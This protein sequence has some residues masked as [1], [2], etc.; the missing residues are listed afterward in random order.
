MHIR[1]QLAARLNL[2]EARVQVQPPPPSAPTSRPL[3]PWVRHY[4]P[5]TLRDTPS[6]TLHWLCPMSVVTCA[7]HVPGREVTRVIR[8]FLSLGSGNGT[9]DGPRHLLPHP[10]FP[11]DHS[12]RTYSPCSL[13]RKIGLDN[14]DQGSTHFPCKGPDGNYVRL[15]RPY[16]HCHNYSN[17]PL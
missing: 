14:L 17:R 10:S 16:G 5:D 4:G 8:Q 12:S 9:G 2:P 1:N 15:W 13:I 6:E 3:G 7:N 11:P